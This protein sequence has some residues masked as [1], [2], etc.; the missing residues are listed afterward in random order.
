MAFVAKKHLS[1]RTFLR[2]AGAALALPLLDSM[3][4]AATA[5][6]QTAAAAKTRF[7]A[8]YFPHGATMY[9]WTPAKEGSA[10]DFTLILQPLEPYRDRINII[11]DLAHPA[12]YGGGSATANHNRSA[13]AFLTGA[14]AE[15]GTQAKC[16]ISLDQALAQKIGQ[17]TPLPSIEMKIEDSTLS[18]DGL[19]CAYRDTISWQSSTSPLPMQ[20]NPQVIFE[21]LFGDGSTD[22]QRRT[23][24][25]KS[26]GLLDAVLSDA[27]SL[28]KSLPANDQK[29]L[30]AYLNDV[31]EIERRIERT[32]QQLSADLDIPPTPTGAPKDFEE[33]IKLM[34]DLWVLSWQADITRISTLMMSKDLSGTV[35]PKSG[36]RDAFHTL[37]HHSNIKDNMDRFA[38]LNKYHVSIF[39]YL[40]EKLKKTED[41]PGSLLDHS[42]I[43]YGSAMSD[44]NQHNHGP[45]PVILAGNATGKLKGGRHIRNAA[46]TTMSNLLVSLSNIMG[47][48]I[49]KFG[50]STGT[51]SI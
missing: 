40:L 14:H 11:S 9:S 8:I 16:G 3:V 24:R 39:T 28:R 43:L 15:A 22:E 17:E 13:A 47:V 48:N 37:S 26:F 12:A 36:V 1:R 51:V 25:T 27:A 19:N 41:G 38:Q 10:F 44:G 45:L 42:M 31:R 34:F 20:N 49:E 4:P 35:Y 23:R 50:D 33:H 46:D 7:G 18:C 6:A 30:D 2:G 21:R 29:R 5:L 32:G